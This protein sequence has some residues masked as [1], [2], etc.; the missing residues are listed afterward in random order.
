MKKAGFTL[1]ELLVVVLIIGILAAIA[2]PQYQKAVAR[3]ELAQIIS[4]TKSIK[5]AQER[6]YLQNGESATSLSNLDISVND[7][8]VKCTVSNEMGGS[9]SCYNKNFSLWAYTNLSYN[10]IECAAKTD[11]LNSAKAAA[12]GEFTKRSSNLCSACSTCSLLG[13]GSCVISHSNMAF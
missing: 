3:A 8:D 2:V 1:I 12:C 11:D 9:I 7:K 5:Q 4:L 13:L 6:Y 10:Y